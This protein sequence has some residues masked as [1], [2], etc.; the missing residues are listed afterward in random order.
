M[1]ILIS[2][3]PGFENQAVVVARL[4]SSLEGD[5]MDSSEKATG[6]RPDNLVVQILHTAV[7]FASHP[8][9]ESIEL[10]TLNLS[11]W[12]HAE[13]GHFL[14]NNG[15]EVVVLIERGAYNYTH[16][17]RNPY[18]FVPKIRL[19]MLENCLYTLLSEKWG[20]PVK[21][22]ESSTV[23]RFYDAST[24]NYSRNK[25]RAIE[26]SKELCF[27]FAQGDKLEARILKSGNRTDHHYADAFNQMMY[28][29]DEYIQPLSGSKRELVFHP[30]EVIDLVE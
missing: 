26:L 19:R 8:K 13:I 23:K 29:I 9:N 20:A 7:S 10:L 28:F 14:Q 30:T 11:T 2:I 16:S 15:N 1:T 21:L 4:S 17:A 5:S 25:S 12:I 22:L 3:D 27:R 24:G 18:A 6:L